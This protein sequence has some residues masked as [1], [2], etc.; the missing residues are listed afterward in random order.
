MRSLVI[1]VSGDKGVI[2]TI[3]IDGND[4]ESYR[5]ITGEKLLEVIEKEYV[6]NTKLSLDVFFRGSSV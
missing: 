6:L 1:N 3:Q 4:S 2:F 5:Q